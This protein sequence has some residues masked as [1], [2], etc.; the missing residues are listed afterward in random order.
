MDLVGAYGRRVLVETA[1]SSAL[2]RTS[3]NRASSSS[4]PRPQPE[5]NAKNDFDAPI[6]GLWEHRAGDY[7]RLSGLYM[8]LFEGQTTPL[9]G[10][11]ALYKAA[12][13][14]DAY[15]VTYLAP[16]EFVGFAQDVLDCGRFRIQRFFS[17]CGTLAEPETTLSSLEQ[18]EEFHLSVS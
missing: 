17:Q 9:E 8:R 13:E 3:K 14:A 11:I 4:L 6:G 5:E 12:F 2:L 1:S 16:L 18:T 10:V 15:K 7:F